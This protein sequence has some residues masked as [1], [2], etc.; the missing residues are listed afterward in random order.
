MKSSRNRVLD[1]FGWFW[2]ES[3]RFALEASPTES[4]LKHT[5]R[6]LACGSLRVTVKENHGRKPLGAE[7][8]AQTMLEVSGAPLLH[9][10]SSLWPDIL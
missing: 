6:M 7:F 10:R 2:G 8:F 3:L 1:G 5:N 4:T 9:T